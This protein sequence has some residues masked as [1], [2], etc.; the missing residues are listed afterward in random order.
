MQMACPVLNESCLREEDR[1]RERERG[2]RV[3]S[4]RVSGRE[5]QGKGK[6]RRGIVLRKGEGEAV[7]FGVFRL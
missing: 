6:G 2:G 5:K 4:S 1:E 7:G 3:E